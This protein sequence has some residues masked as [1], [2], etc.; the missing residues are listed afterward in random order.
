MEN[1]VRYYN[2]NNNFVK[3]FI[4][5]SFQKKQL[6]K[7]FHVYQ[8]LV[9]IYEKKPELISDIFHNIHYLG[10]WK[11]CFFAL[12]A[13]DTLVQK[14]YD[15]NDF[16]V[17]MY[18]FLIKTLNI[19]VEK[20][21]K[22]KQISMLA[23]WMPRENRSFDKKI[24][25]VD[26]FT[27][28]RYAMKG[29]YVDMD[30]LIRRKMEYRKELSKLNKYLGTGEINFSNQNIV[31]E[32]DFNKMTDLCIT[33]NKKKIIENEVLVAKYKS[34]LTTKYNSFS[35]W[36]FVK[37]VSR[38]SLMDDCNLEKNIAKNIWKSS[39]SKFVD[40]INTIIDF[41]QEFNILVDLSGDMVKNN[42]LPYI[43]GIV[44]LAKSVKMSNKVFCVGKSKEIVQNTSDIFDIISTIRRNMYPRV[45]TEYE[46]DSNKQLLIITN[47]IGD[48]SDYD[49]IWRL[50]YSPLQID[51]E[52]I[53]GIPNF[54]INKSR[55]I[56]SNIISKHFPEKRKVFYDDSIILSTHVE[57]WTIYS[58][59]L[60]FFILSFF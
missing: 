35:F 36:E 60:Y 46:F 29:N 41:T 52:N 3:N 13:A 34:F 27:A 2:V 22:R 38:L 57:K 1:R 54:K 43:F 50:N 47:D 10:Y 40:E 26:N 8:Q 24:N 9:I 45:D 15:V 39:L 56:L 17:F 32:A 59:M 6:R 51:E 31:H 42:F 58:I 48:F 30:N 21:Q 44:I 33:K 16:I 4:K 12:V 19:D 14:G 18:K 23:K 37:E 25:F 28:F 11:D 5:N 20:C 55:E 7:P 49:I 53:T